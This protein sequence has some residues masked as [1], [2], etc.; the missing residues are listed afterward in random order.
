MQDDFFSIYND[1]N[2][3]Q[4]K[5]KRV[6]KE[7][8]AKVASWYKEITHSGFEANAQEVLKIA[9]GKLAEMVTVQLEKLH[10]IIT[11]AG[12]PAPPFTYKDINGKMVNL[13]DFAGKFVLIDVWATWCAPCREEMPALQKIEENLKG[14][15]IVFVGVSI[16]KPQHEKIWKRMVAEKALGGTQLISEGGWQ[17]RFMV[18]Y[19]I[20]A[21]PTYIIIGP[22]GNVIDTD[23]EWPSRGLERQLKKLLRD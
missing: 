8:E 19:G 4:A 2:A 9:A 6:S 3:Y 5:Y 12:N 23:A 22:D 21:V 15:N 1:C 11:M 13:S 7:A 20:H 18:D 17:S 14:Q 10:R 16:D